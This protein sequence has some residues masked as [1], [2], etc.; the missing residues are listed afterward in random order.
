MQPELI[1]QHVK[2]DR[3]LFD[4]LRS[5]YQA[6]RG[7]WTSLFSV[8]TLSWVKFVQ[9]ELYHGELADVGKIND[10]PPPEHVECR[11]AP[12]LPDVLPPI[13]DTKMMHREY[14]SLTAPRSLLSTEL[15][16]FKYFKIL[17]VQPI[18]P[19]SW[20]DSPK[21]SSSSHCASAASANPLTPGWGIQFLVSWD[22]PKIWLISLFFFG[23]G[24][25]LIG[26]LWGVFKHS[27]QDAFEIATYVVAFGTVSVGSVQA[28]LIM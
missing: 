23:F 13:G 4:L 10:M 3:A 11:Y 21:N 24:S 22:I 25:A 27:I 18:A 5:S 16:L 14:L 7:N 2:S 1:D 8:Q 15:M 12:A 26:I 9:F 17:Y 6:T 19:G 28:L 20:R